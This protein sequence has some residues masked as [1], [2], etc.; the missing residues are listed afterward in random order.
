[1]KRLTKRDLRHI[2]CECCKNWWDWCDCGLSICTVCER[3]ESQHCQCET[4]EVESVKTPLRRVVRERDRAAVDEAVR[5]ALRRVRL[6]LAEVK[7]VE[8]KVDGVVTHRVVVNQDAIGRVRRA[9]TTAAAVIGKAREADG[10]VAG[11]PRP[12]RLAVRQACQQLADYQKELARLEE[13]S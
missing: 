6:A 10:T 8:R 11:P 5:E 2:P 9:Y 7:V 13:P 12:D 4:G 1:M 3:C